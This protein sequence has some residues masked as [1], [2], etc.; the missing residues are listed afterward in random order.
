MRCTCGE[1]GQEGSIY[2][3][4][5]C[6]VVGR[7]GADTLHSMADLVCEHRYNM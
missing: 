4:C 3:R 7:L 5:V 2:G 1:A 6:G